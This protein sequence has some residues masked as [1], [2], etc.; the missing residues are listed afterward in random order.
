M[1]E[2]DMDNLDKLY[3]TISALTLAQLQ[4]LLIETLV[5]VMS[6]EI[7]E[8]QGFVISEMITLSAVERMAAQVAIAE[9]A[10]IN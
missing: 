9:G 6:G 8:D 5:A 7:T 1:T 2:E 3:A 4:T 10:V